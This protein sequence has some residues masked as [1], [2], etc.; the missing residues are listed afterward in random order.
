MAAAIW[1][2]SPAEILGFPAAT[3]LRFCINHRLLQIE[4]RPE[5]C[6]IVGGGRACVNKMA[7]S[8]DIRLKHPVE[9]VRREN[10]GVKLTAR[11]VTDE[12]DRVIFATHAPDTL[13]ML[14][15]AD[16]REGDCWN[17]SGTSLTWRY[18]IRIGVSCPGVNLS[19][20][21]G[22]TCPWM[23]TAVR[24]VSPTC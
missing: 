17:R 20:R 7:E 12:Y 18:R 5:W 1:S 10:G 13:G 19:G 21:P 22:T 4:G 11:G 6:S 2:S 23:M 16:S 24:S 8:L 9:Q 14:K 15:D 3:F